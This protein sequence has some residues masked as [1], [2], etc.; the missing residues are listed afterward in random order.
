VTPLRF[1][2]DAIDRYFREHNELPQ[3]IA[4]SPE[5]FRD[6]VSDPK[7]RG[8]VFT[9]R[10]GTRFRGIEIVQRSGIEPSFLGYDGQLEAM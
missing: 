9:Y 6:L 8:I 1:I 10:H 2:D 4:L 7:S 5:T 3:C